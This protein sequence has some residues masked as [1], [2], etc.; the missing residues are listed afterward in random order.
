MLSLKCAA[1]L[2]RRT[3]GIAFAGGRQAR[4]AIMAATPANATIDVLQTP[5]PQKV[6]CQIAALLARPVAQDMCHVGFC[7]YGSFMLGALIRM[8]NYMKAYDMQV[9]EYFCWNITS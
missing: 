9:L 4:L 1:L 6:N 8:H 3:T 2:S 7:E 5:H